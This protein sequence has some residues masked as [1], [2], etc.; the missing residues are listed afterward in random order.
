[1]LQYL[2]V[3]TLTAEKVINM[4]D[5]LIETA[6]LVEKV[7]QYGNRYRSRYPSVNIGLN[8]AEQ[9]FRNYQL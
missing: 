3:A 9:S 6:M 1:M 4:T 5:E 8:E 2:E 7:I